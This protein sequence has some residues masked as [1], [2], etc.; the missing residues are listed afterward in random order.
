MGSLH[1]WK[2]AC[3][4]I[5]SAHAALVHPTIVWPVLIF[6]EGVVFLGHVRD[7]DSGDIGEEPENQKAVVEQDTD[8]LSELQSGINQLL[9]SPLSNPCYCINSSLTFLCTYAEGLGYGLPMSRL[10]AQYFGGSLKGWKSV[11]THYVRCDGV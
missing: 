10:Y 5:I 1:I 3:L 9:D 4:S 8:G 11:M 2:T 7:C 6:P